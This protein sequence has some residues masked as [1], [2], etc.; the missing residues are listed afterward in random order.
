MPLGSLIAGAFS[1]KMAT[2]SVAERSLF[3]C[4]SADAF[5]KDH[6]PVSGSGL[7]SI[8]VFYS[9]FRRL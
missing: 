8:G 4:G 1:K 5:S 2:V 6:S 7:G 9:N 3:S